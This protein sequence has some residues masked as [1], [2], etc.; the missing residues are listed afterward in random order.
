MHPKHF[1]RRTTLSCFADS[2]PYESK[3]ESIPKKRVKSFKPSGDYVYK[4]RLTIAINE[5]PTIFLFEIKGN[6]VL[7]SDPKFNEV[8]T[9]ND[10]YA[11]VV[12]DHM[13]SDTYANDYA[14]CFDDYSLSKYTDCKI[15]GCQDI[16]TQVHTYS[17]VDEY[18]KVAD[19]DARRKII[20]Q[21]EAAARILAEKARLD[22][23]D[24]GW[25]DS[26]SDDSDED[27]PG[28]QELDLRADI[29]KYKEDDEDK[30]RAMIQDEA[31]DD[32][33]AITEDDAEEFEIKQVLSKY[34]ENKKLVESKRPPRDYPDISFSLIAMERIICMDSQQMRQADMRGLIE[35]ELEKPLLSVLKSDDEDET[36]AAEGEIDEDAMVSLLIQQHRMQEQ[37]EKGGGV[38]EGVPT[39]IIPDAQD[40][41]DRKESDEDDDLLKEA[42][43]EEE[44]ERKR[45]EQIKA[46]QEAAAA[47]AAE[48]AAAA[49]AAA[50]KAEEKDE[51]DMAV[52][53]L[54]VAAK[55][56]E[57]LAGFLADQQSAMVPAPEQSETVG[58]GAPVTGATT[59]TAP[60]ISTMVEGAPDSGSKEEQ[61]T[62]PS[63][64]EPKTVPDVASLVPPVQAKATVSPTIPYIPIPSQGGMIGGDTD[65]KCTW[66]ESDEK[67][68]EDKRLEEEL[69]KGVPD[70]IDDEPLKLPQFNAEEGI[71]DDEEVATHGSKKH[72]KELAEMMD[73]GENED[74]KL[75]TADQKNKPNDTKSTSAVQQTALRPSVGEDDTLNKEEKKVVE[76]DEFDDISSDSTHHENSELSDHVELEEDA[77][78]E[79]DISITRPSIFDPRKR[80]H[81][82]KY[83]EWGNDNTDEP[84][85]MVQGAHLRQ[86]WTFKCSETEGLEVTDLTHHPLNE[87]IIA[88]SYG[89]VRFG[90]HEKEGLICLWNAK[91][92]RS[93]ERMYKLRAPATCLAFSELT[94]F[95]LAVG[96]LDGNVVLLDIREDDAVILG[97]TVDQKISYGHLGPVWQ[98]YW[99]IEVDSSNEDIELES[100]LT[101][102]DDGLLKKWTINKG[103]ES[104]ILM[105][106]GR[107]T[108]QVP[109]RREKRSESLIT[110]LS[111]AYT[112]CFFPKSSDLFLLGTE[113]GFVHKCSTAYKE[114]YLSTYVGH[115]GPVFRVTFSP[116][117]DTVFISCGGDWTVK[118][119]KLE[120]SAPLLTLQ[121]GHRTI[122]DV[123]CSIFL[124]TVFIC[125]TEYRVEVWDLSQNT[126]E[127]TVGFDPPFSEGQRKVAFNG[128]LNVRYPSN[129]I[130]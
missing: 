96:M 103:L 11:E 58:G 126:L 129:L 60:E 55:G 117:D 24:L 73:D 29:S 37:L 84:P 53:E 6:M 69:S 130:S 51:F 88:A 100:M 104:V 1:F 92:N 114:S 76:E 66:T 18:I 23:P 77:S 109:G 91:N 123:T 21:D 67:L 57:S 43:A 62:P 32:D 10:R 39:I 47:A 99:I 61:A 45:Q 33:I 78:T 64:S 121:T 120:H 74:G 65:L 98:V 90:D 118:L 93:P 54:Q 105:K 116:F 35:P 83:S 128:L 56:G 42:D 41:G 8:K 12:K 16:G 72:K 86:Y 44:A 34:Y 19:E 38:D 63:A 22:I 95:V 4:T 101:L 87:N 108:M 5:T 97:A 102:G 122:F 125:L 20:E 49:A 26:D 124:S 14:Q 9:N 113:E 30:H 50:E 115:T 70:V 15:R 106:V 59:T 31:S 13:V 112:V 107:S 111:I 68:D 40:M 27:I 48:A 127:P 110:S 89:S 3:K 79:S 17:I 25:K 28:A 46:E 80:S 75:E 81:D 7:E 85:P 36:K 2:R 82:S 119:W 94:P 71:S 52:E